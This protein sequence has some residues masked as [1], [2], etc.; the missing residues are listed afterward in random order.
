MRRC[1]GQRARSKASCASGA[2]LSFSVTKVR[3][4]L[5]ESHTVYNHQLN[6]FIAT[7]DAGSFSKSGEALNVSPT[8]VMKQI[9]LLEDALDVRLFNRTPHGL[10]L[11]AAGASYYED[12]KYMIRY[13]R[14]AAV[15]AKNAALKGGDMIRLGNSLMTPCG[16]LVDMWPRIHEKFPE[17]K[18][19]IINYENTPENAREIL[20]NLGQ[21]IDVVAGIFD[22]T[23][24][25]LRGCDAVEL[26]RVPI[27]VA[28]PIHHTL[29]GKSRLKISDLY[30]CRLLLICRGWSRYMDALR[31]DISARHPQIDIVDFPFYN[32]D[33]F[34]RAEHEGMLLAAVP[35]FSDVHPL[36]KVVSVVWEHEMPFGFLFSHNPSASVKRFLDAAHD[37]YVPMRRS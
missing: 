25:N 29:A 6:T 5:R 35:F 36:L 23:L 13:A 33:V 18:F 32:L 22:D 7:A 31:D 15:R 10:T 26:E 3:A 8:A 37:A 14:E 12:A 19:E 16:F 1:V 4:R 11:T 9:N 28:V 27:C 30:G 24:L 34:N 20:K 2:L 21:N 17:L